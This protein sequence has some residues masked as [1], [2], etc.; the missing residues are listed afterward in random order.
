MKRRITGLIIS[1]M[2]FCTGSLYSA[3]EALLKEFSGK[4]EGGNG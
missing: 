2:V 3:Q 4:V 1:I